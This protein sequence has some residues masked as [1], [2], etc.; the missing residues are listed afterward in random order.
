MLPYELLKKH[1][2]PRGLTA[3]DG[4]GT[5]ISSPHPAYRGEGGAGKGPEG[6]RCPGLVA[7]ERCLS[8]PGLLGLRADDGPPHPAPG[9]SWGDQSSP[10]PRGS[11]PERG[12]QHMSSSQEGRPGNGLGAGVCSCW[13]GPGVPAPAGLALSGPHCRGWALVH[14][15]GQGDRDSCRVPWAPP[16]CHLASLSRTPLTTP[17]QVPR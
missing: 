17:R 10:V 5:P 2:L 9:V 4:R 12:Q 11:L 8:A 15:P 13:P 3:C 16:V 7:A 6:R 14:P 1:G